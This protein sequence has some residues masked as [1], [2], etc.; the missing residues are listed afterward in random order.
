ME[1]RGQFYIIAAFVILIAFAGLT[2]VYTSV[3]TPVKRVVIYDLAEEVHYEMN[4]LIN[5]RVFAGESN[6][7]VAQDIKDFAIYYTN[8]NPNIEIAMIYGD[9]SEIYKINSTDIILLT[10]ANGV[11][12]I[13]LSGDQR[14][15]EIKSG[16]K[17]FYVMLKN[18]IYGEK[19]IAVK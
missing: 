7:E 16:Q 18:E 2:Y 13:E 6:S 5:N 4:Q 9:Q 14:D 11:V 12:S 19:N 1:K 8:R 10:P 17:N 15:F 3:R